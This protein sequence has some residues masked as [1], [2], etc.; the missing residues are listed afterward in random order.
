MI[1]H[2]IVAVRPHVAH[3]AWELIVGIPHHM[4]YDEPLLAGR[5][6]LR[7]AHIAEIRRRFIAYVSRAFA[8]HIVGVYQ[9]AHR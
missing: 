3:R 5:K 7:E 9:S 8:E 4:A 6:E 2:G 1:S